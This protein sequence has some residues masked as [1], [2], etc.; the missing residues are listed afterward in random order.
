MN[1]KND[2]RPF[3]YK[4]VLE[5]HEIEPGTTCRIGDVDVQVMEQFHGH[6]KSLGFR[7]GPVAYSTDVKEMP[8][9]TFEALEGVKA[10][11]VGAPVTHPN[12]PTHIHVD[13]A[14]EWIERVNPERAFISHLGLD[15]DYET[16]QKDLP[17]RVELTYDGMIIEA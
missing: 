5:P 13:G 4:P 16:I 2:P 10:W 15:I 9:S 8:E 7:F 1:N 6:R 14:L 17:D 11:I 12:H 3:Y